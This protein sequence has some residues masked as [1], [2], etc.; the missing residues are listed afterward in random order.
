[1]AS[2]F[3]VSRDED[4]NGVTR[5]HGIVAGIPERRWN[6]RKGCCIEV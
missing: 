1:M 6:F 3:G 4:V 2:S 5:A